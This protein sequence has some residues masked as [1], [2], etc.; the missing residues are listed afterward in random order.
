MPLRIANRIKNETADL[1]RFAFP[2]HFMFLYNAAT[3]RHPSGG[4]C[5]NIK[6]HKPVM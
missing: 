3:G 5:Y 4:D 2:Q 6:E 1:Q